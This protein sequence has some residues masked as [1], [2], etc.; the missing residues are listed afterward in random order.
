MERIVVG[1][2]GSEGSQRA[3]RWAIAEARL[4]HA[5]VDAV[6]A[7]HAP[8]LLATPYAPAPSIDPS[9]FEGEARAILERAV[10]TEVA[11]GVPV[12]RVLVCGPAAPTLLDHAKDA[13][14]LV[15]GSRGRGGFAGLLLG[16]VSQQVVAHAECP[17]VVIPAHAREDD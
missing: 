14:L 8:Y 12:H 6:H 10:E 16:S 7:W 17:V 11:D 13:D 3:L 15:V 2:D 5:S 9:E 4:R 1:V